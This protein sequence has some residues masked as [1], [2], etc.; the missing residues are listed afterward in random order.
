MK[1]I[2]ISIKRRWADDILEG[3]KTVELRKTKPAGKTDANG[4]QYAHDM[5]YIVSTPGN[6]IIGLA[7]VN[8]YTSI[9][10]ALNEYAPGISGKKLLR[11]ACVSREEF[12]AYAPKF[13]WELSY[14]VRFYVP[15]PLDAIG[16]NRPPQSWQYMTKA[17]LNRLA[18]QMALCYAKAY[19]MGGRAEHQ[20]S[21]H[22]EQLQRI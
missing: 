5:A 10:G 16:I 4:Y 22:H 12:S 6:C 15:V 11:D 7:Q 18:G 14:P 21:P 13:S 1:K 8:L 20:R 17:Q 3:R 2:L 19:H 9:N